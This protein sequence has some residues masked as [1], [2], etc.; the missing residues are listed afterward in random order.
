MKKAERAVPRPIAS[1]LLVA[2][3]LLLASCGFQLRGAS[4]VTLPPE[5]QRLRVTMGG[6]GFP[7]LLVEMRNALLALG[8][9]RLTEDVSAAVPVLQLYGESSVN[10]VLAIDSSG[11]ISAYLLNYRVDF[12][13]DGADGKVLLPSQPVK[14]QREITFDRLNVIA[15]E[16]QGEFLQNEMR[17]DA[18]QQILRRLARLNYATARDGGS[19]ENAGAAFPPTA[20]TEAVSPLPV[21]DGHANQR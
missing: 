11:R 5:L 17:R 2:C 16:K 4:S 20:N 13:L 21:V 1:W 6:A 18:T 12:S 14:L 19:A 10:Q 15:T 9:V 7:P 3:C 8:T